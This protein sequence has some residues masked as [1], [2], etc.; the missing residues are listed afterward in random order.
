[1]IDGNFTLS[2]QLTEIAPRLYLGSV[3]DLKNRALIESK[4]ITA[5]V[6]VCRYV[7]HKEY[8]NCIRIHVP[9]EDGEGNT[10]ARFTCAANNVYGLLGAYRETVFVHCRAGMSRSP[11]VVAAAYAKY[12]GVTFREAVA[13]IKK[14][15]DI[16]INPALFALGDEYVT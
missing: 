7:P 1:M 16:S 4:G 14:V 13:Y 11:A 15:R 6:S 12:R 2:T 3:N 9:L 10:L 8:Q 5:I